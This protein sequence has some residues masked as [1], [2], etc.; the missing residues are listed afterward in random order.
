MGKQHQGMD[1]PGV[2]QVPEGSGEQGK[3]EKTGCEIICGAPTT[4]AVKG[5]MIMMM[6]EPGFAVVS[7]SLSFQWRHRSVT[8]LDSRRSAVKCEPHSVLLRPHVNC[9]IPTPVPELSEKKFTSVSGSCIKIP[10]ALRINWDGQ[11]DS[12]AVD[13]LGGK[14]DPKV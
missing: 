4:P 9:I 2:H 13:F 6:I 12:A 8:L 10:P 11:R 1:R 7:V 14:S 3:M 5:Q